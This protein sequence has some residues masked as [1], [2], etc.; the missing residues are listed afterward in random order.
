MF[1]FT[2]V[3][4]FFRFFIFCVPSRSAG[5]AALHA[6]YPEVFIV[7]GEIDSGLNQMVG[8]LAYHHALLLWLS[9]N[10]LYSKIV[11]IILL[12]I[13]QPPFFVIT[14]GQ[15]RFHFFFFLRSLQWNFVFPSSPSSLTSLLFPQLLDLQNY[16]IPGLG[17]YGDRFYG[18]N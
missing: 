4:L 12:S 17:D 1:L 13:W 8:Q 16:I 2:N 18:T 3:F 10:N 6:S 15:K 14:F 7:T 9:S 11:S 5:I